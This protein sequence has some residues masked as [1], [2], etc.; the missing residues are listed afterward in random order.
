MWTWKGPGTTLAA[1]AIRCVLYLMATI[2]NQVNVKKA[3]AF[4][5]LC[6]KPSSFSSLRYNWAKEHSAVSRF[7]FVHSILRC[8]FLRCSFGLLLIGYGKVSWILSDA[9]WL[10]IWTNCWLSQYLKIETGR[11]SQF[12]ENTFHSA[13]RFWHR[14]S[15]VVFTCLLQTH[16]FCSCKFLFEIVCLIFLTTAL[17]HIACHSVDLKN[18]YLICSI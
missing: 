12:A 7:L 14:T 1:A 8:F 13:R 15:V 4:C 9:Y 6:L 16:V 11:W 3:R 17:L 2:T 18:C 5:T 10:K